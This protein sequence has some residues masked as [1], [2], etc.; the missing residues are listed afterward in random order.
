M[1]EQ[2]DLFDLSDNQEQEET[3]LPQESSLT[4]RQWQTYNLIKHNS[5]VEHR[6]TTQ[7]EIYEKVGGYEWVDDDKIHDHCSAIWKDIKDNNES[8]EHDKIIISKNFQY[9][10]GS[11][12]ETQRY[13]RD[14]WRALAPRLHRYWAY[15]QKTKLDGLGKILDKN[16]NTIISTTSEFHR[17]FN[18]YDIELQELIAKDKEEDKKAKKGTDNELTN[19][20]EGQ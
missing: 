8:L 7:R 17:C 20:N 10:I 12:R 14:L 19:D 6:K 3:R 1:T 16:G 13:L 2:L 4:P 11:E 18:D 15:V 5:L 9:W